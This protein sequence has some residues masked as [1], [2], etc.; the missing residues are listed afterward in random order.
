MNRHF[1]EKEIQMVHEHIFKC[2]N[3]LVQSLQINITR[4]YYFSLTRMAK[5]Y[6]VV[7]IKTE[8]WENNEKISPTEG[9]LK[10]VQS[11]W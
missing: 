10:L 5:F 6:K 1:I 9:E 2:L 8:R 4:K 3:L 7:N 11:L